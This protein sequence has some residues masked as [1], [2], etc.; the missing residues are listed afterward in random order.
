MGGLA[1]SGSEETRQQS[2]QAMLRRKID[3]QAFDVFLCYNHHDKSVVKHIGEQL[4]RHGIL[5]WLDEWELRPGEPWQRA[6]EEQIRKTKM[7]IVFV[8]S[9]GMGP[10]HDSEM[11][12]ILRQMKLRDCRVIPVWLLGTP[13]HLELSL[14]LEEMFWVDF[15]LQEPDPM[16]QLL[17]GITGQK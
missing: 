11:Y 10:W 9:R 8:G 3:T 14:F 7:A 12:A 4:K 6:L 1:Q 15:R 16:R 5:P 2:V 17:W 13:E